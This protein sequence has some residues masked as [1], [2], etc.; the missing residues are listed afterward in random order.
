LRLSRDIYNHQKGSVKAYEE[1]KG[2][3]VFVGHCWAAHVAE[4]NEDDRKSTVAPNEDSYDQNTC[5]GHVRAQELAVR[6]DAAKA[7]YELEKASIKAYEDG[8][9]DWDGP[10]WPWNQTDKT[11]L[12]ASAEEHYDN[13][14]TPPELSKAEV[15]QKPK[16]EL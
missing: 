1:G 4:T 2:N 9:D 16:S 13:G 11:N 7:A 8:W 10:V 12:S 15:V 3:H 5:L 14:Y 6:A